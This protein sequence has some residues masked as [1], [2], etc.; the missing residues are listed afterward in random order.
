MTSNCML[1]WV[2]TMPNH[3]GRSLPLLMEQSSQPG[4]WMKP[5]DSKTTGIIAIDS[6]NSFSVVLE[7]TEYIDEPYMAASIAGQRVVWFMGESEGL[8][9][10]FEKQEA[11]RRAVESWLLPMQWDCTWTKKPRVFR[12]KMLHHFHLP[13]ISYIR[14]HSTLAGWTTLPGSTVEYK[15]QQY[16]DW[17]AWTSY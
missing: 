14:S 11:C 6:T 13:T 15:A 16:Q 2:V 4:S 3:N 9:E 17:G 8:V 5:L 10:S 1:M 7:F 12:W